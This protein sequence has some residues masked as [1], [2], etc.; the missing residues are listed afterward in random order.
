MA[1]STVSIAAV[2]EEKYDSPKNLSTRWSFRTSVKTS[3]A[4]W[5]GAAK[6]S[7]YAG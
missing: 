1:L 5:M 6:S 7:A 4:S 3:I 2:R